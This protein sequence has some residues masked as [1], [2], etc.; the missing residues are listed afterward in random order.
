MQTI[1]P[2]ARDKFLSAQIDWSSDAFL[3]V[4][5]GSGSSFSD[6]DEFRSDLTGVLG[7]GSLSGMSMPGGGWADAN[8]VTI[9]GLTPGQVVTGF[10]I[11]V[12]T[13]SAATDSLVWFTDTHSD[14]TPIARTVD[15]SGSM[16]FAFSS[17]PG[18]IFQL[19][20]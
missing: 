8:D 4:A 15:G 14:T 1:Y 16:T 2:L 6:L 10:V 5:L 18:R 19:G 20:S 11:C 17:A 13:G 3:A 12:D 9:T 7:T